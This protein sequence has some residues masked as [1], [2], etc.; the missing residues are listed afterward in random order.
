MKAITIKQP[1][2]FCITHLDKSLENRNW[3]LP[4]GMVGQTIAI[5]TSKKLD[6]IH[7]RKEAYRMAG[8]ALSQLDDHMPL[9]CIV[10]TA[11]IS[12]EAYFDSDGCRRL[13][14]LMREPDEQELARMKNWFVGDYGFWLTDVTSLKEP[15]PCRGQ[16]GFWTI[17]AEIQQRL[18]A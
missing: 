18:N 1:W 2:A 6:D 4:N 11:V 13:R 15:I 14:Q 16:L 10:A 8:F 12:G 7:G 5:H 17:P 9:G 3:K